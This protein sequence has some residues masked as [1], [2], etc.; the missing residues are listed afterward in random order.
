MSYVTLLAFPFKI[1]K[2]RRRLLPFVA[3]QAHQKQT[4]ALRDL[5]RLFLRHFTRA[6]EHFQCFTHHQLLSS[7]SRSRGR[8][9]PRCRLFYVSFL[10][11]TCRFNKIGSSTG[12][13]LG[14]RTRSKPDHAERRWKWLAM[15]HRSPA[16]SWTWLRLPRAPP[17][18][19]DATATALRVF[20][21]AC[22]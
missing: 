22:S 12:P 15:A 7:A 21:R 20:H 6:Y 14:G 1:N 5:N 10:A 13:R 3:L 19:E 11:L 16:L 18:P 2:L 9:R 8:E 4:G 17:R